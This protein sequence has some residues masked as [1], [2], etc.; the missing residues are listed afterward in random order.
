VY[1]NIGLVTP[2]QYEGERNQ[3]YL[4]ELVTQRRV[5]LLIF[6]FSSFFRREAS[7]LEN[8]SLLRLAEG[9]EIKGIVGVT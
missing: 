9:M 8:F 4:L 5:F 2:R 1:C 7:P 6:S 3:G